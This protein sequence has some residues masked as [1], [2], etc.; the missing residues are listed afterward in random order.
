MNKTRRTEIRTIAQDA[1]EIQSQME[2][3]LARLELV[4]SDEE[5]A[6]D[7]MP[8]NLKY[9]FRGEEAEEAVNTMENVLDSMREIIKDLSSIS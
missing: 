9:S 6:Y 5:Y 2:S 3:L 1:K 7:N 4:Y 8:D